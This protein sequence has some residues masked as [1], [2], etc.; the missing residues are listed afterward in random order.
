MAELFLQIAVSLDG[1][2]E[3]ANQN[4]EW[5][6]FDPTVDP[7][8]TSTLQSIDGMIF[9]RRAH[10]L[11]N[12]FW[13]RGAEVPGASEDLIEQA[14]LMNDLPKYVLTHGPEATGWANSHTIRI[15]DITK[16][17]DQA[18]RPIAL[19]AGASAAQS[20]LQHDLVD[21]I[22]L[23]QQPVVLGAGT[24]LFA[25]DGKRRNL[26]L[27]ECRTFASGAVLSRYRVKKH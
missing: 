21:E 17:K 20:A 6:E 9:G 27:I 18:S 23:I 15:D 22:R 7:V 26:M 11:L 3:D 14:R 19:F 4:I 24:P 10:A 1:Y 25:A 5:M 2:I 12:Q 16:L 8:I 13:P